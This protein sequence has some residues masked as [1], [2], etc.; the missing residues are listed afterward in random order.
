MADGEGRFA[1]MRKGT[2]VAASPSS[3]LAVQSYP[4]SVVAVLTALTLVFLALQLAAGV[5]QSDRMYPVTGYPMFS[6][7]SDGLNVDLVLEGVTVDGTATQVRAEELGLTEL[8]LRRNLA[9]EVLSIDVEHASTRLGQIASIWSQREQRELVE[10]SLWRVE[11]WVDGRQIPP[12]QV[13]AWA[14]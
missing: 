1:G 3:A 5:R 7:T 13:A 14:R 8:Q 2:P 4:R 12:E 11:R 9:H 6:H 10:L